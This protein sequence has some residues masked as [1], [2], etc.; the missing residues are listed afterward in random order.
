M[1]LKVFLLG[2]EE[3]GKT[4]IIYRIVS[5]T[6]TDTYTATIGVDFQKYKSQDS[7][8]NILDASG[9]KRFRSLFPAFYKEVDC[10][11]VV[12]DVTNQKSIQIT[13]NLINNLIK[14]DSSNKSKI[15]LVA[16][17]IDL[18]KNRVI[19][20]G[21]I[22]DI[23]SEYEIGEE[24]IFEV[25]AKNGSGIDVLKEKIIQ[26]SAENQQTQQPAINT[27]FHKAKISKKNESSYS[28]F[29]SAL[30]VGLIILEFIANLLLS[31]LC[32]AL[33]IIGWYFL[34]R[35]FQRNDNPFSFFYPGCCGEKEVVLDDLEEDD[36]YTP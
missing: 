28:C 20:S 30:K 6:F 9:Q 19:T 7:S 26:F 32:L 36:I 14:S 10:F 1:Q 4:S 33:P 12:I 27:R 18:C 17:K 24:L 5:D 15:I 23:A 13:R 3:S 16:N 31:L 22:V 34:L 35:N 8:I 25:S 29:A 21:Q 2:I 11:V